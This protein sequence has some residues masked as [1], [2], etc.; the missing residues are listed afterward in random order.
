[1]ALGISP[2]HSLFDLVAD[3]HAVVLLH[4]GADRDGVVIGTGLDVVE[5]I[6]HFP[7]R[8]DDVV[9]DDHGAPFELG[10]EDLQVLE[11]VA[12]EGRR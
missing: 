11:I 3:R 2:T 7:S 5:E 12:L 6:L 10:L 1:M 8:L 9:R 4:G